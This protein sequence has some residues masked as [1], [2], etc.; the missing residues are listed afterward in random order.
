MRRRDFIA[1]VSASVWTHVALGQQPEV[2]V[3][4]FFSAGSA[5][6]KPWPQL[7]AAFRQGLQDTGFVE[8]RN[9]AIEYRW[10]ENQYDRLP[11]LAAELVGR[12]VAVIV[13]N[14][15]AHDAAKAATTKIPIVFISG[16]DPVRQGLVS[17][18]NRPG[19]NL[20]G[21]YQFASGLEAKRLSLLHDL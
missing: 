10:A 8:N 11:A 3:I 5:G 15:R 4:A 19:G 14:P 9:V 17:N 21:V 1:G 13:A 18:L 12:G 2:P 6:T 20:T 7:T 16:G